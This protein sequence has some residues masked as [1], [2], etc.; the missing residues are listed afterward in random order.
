MGQLTGQIPWGEHKYLEQIEAREDGG[1]P[2]FLQTIRV[3]LC[4]KLKEKMGVENMLK[5]EEEIMQILWNGFKEIDNLHILADNIPQRLGVISFY[6]EDLH[7]NL[8]VKLLND[9]FGIQVRGG[10]SCAGT[11]GHYLLHV[12]H[13]KSKNITDQ[14][15]IGNLLEKP[16]W[17]RLSIH[18]IM[19]NEEIFIILD[20]VRQLAENHKAWKEDYNYQLKTNEFVHKSNP[21]FENNLT[22]VWFENDLT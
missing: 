6:I 15:N 17:I 22:K 16:G 7:Y 4:V 13:E 14:I 10:C 12:S 11:Y 18:P 2:G 20:A 8:G 19:T 1:T 9:R 21:S 5:R 3:A